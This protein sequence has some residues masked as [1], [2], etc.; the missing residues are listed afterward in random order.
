MATRIK[1]RG[2]LEPGGVLTNSRSQ[3][4][5]MFSAPLAIGPWSESLIMQKRQRLM[6]NVAG[7]P[8]NDLLQAARLRFDT[9]EA[10]AK[11]ERGGRFG[12]GSNDCFNRASY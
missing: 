3:I 5:N 8:M 4:K 6:K 1:G 2:W 7:V 12:V 9:A 10:R 11:A